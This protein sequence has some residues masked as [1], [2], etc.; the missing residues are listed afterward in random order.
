[1]SLMSS[2][3]M[4]AWSVPGGVEGDRVADRDVT[5]F[6]DRRVHPEHQ[7]SPEF[8]VSDAPN[9][10]DRLQHLERARPVGRIMLGT[11]TSRDR[12]ADPERAVANGGLASSPTVL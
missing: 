11:N 9:L 7:A 1:M 5:G 4:V 8:T 3:G 6:D 10:I 12:S 2:G